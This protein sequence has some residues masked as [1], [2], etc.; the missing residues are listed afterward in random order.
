MEVRTLAP[1]ACSQAFR[2]AGAAPRVAHELQPF[3]RREEPTVNIRLAT[4]RINNEHR[5]LPV[6]HF[7]GMAAVLRYSVLLSFLF[8]GTAGPDW[9]LEYSS[10]HKANRDRADVN[11]FAV[12]RSDHGLGDHF[13]GSFFALRVAVAL[14][15]VLVLTWPESEDLD[16]FL[17]PGVIDTSPRGRN[18]SDVHTVVVLDEF[19]VDRQQRD[20]KEL[21]N[22]WQPRDQ[23]VGFV[24]NLRWDNDGF[25]IISGL[26]VAKAGD[27]REMF[28]ALFRPTHVLRDIVDSKLKAM[29]AFQKPM[30]FVAVHLRLGGFIGERADID[31]TSARYGGK[32]FTRMA[33][34][35]SCYLEMVSAAQ[36]CA[37]NLSDTKVLAPRDQPVLIISDNAVL[38]RS[39]SL[40][41]LSR[42]IGPPGFAIHSHELYHNHT[43][44][45]HDLAVTELAILARADCLVTSNSG[46]SWLAGVFGNIT[47]LRTVTDCMES[48]AEHVLGPRCV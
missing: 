30:A 1:R 3:L 36:A 44:H 28:A 45:K 42:A 32:R 2:P 20:L 17:G 25:G 10:W 18:F 24:T 39:L 35:G 12:H 47:C 38:R 37:I 16:R 27:D 46:F 22:F 15:R 31:P 11:V 34:T 33:G 4:P 7:T 23:V 6:Q 8:C 29:F 5:W 21:L 9:L 48:F 19:E 43:A 13:R 26:P 14:K 40:G 41:L